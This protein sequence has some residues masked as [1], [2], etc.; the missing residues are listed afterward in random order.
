MHEQRKNLVQLAMARQE[1]VENRG[2]NVRLPIVH[3][4]DELTT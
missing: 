3:S 1:H 2:R 4:C